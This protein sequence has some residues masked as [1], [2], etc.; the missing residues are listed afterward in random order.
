MHM[1]SLL[2]SRYALYL[3]I[4]PRLSFWIYIERLPVFHA[5]NTSFPSYFSTYAL[6]DHSIHPSIHH[7]YHFLSPPSSP[8]QFQNTFNQT[9]SPALGQNRAKS[10]HSSH[11]PPSQIN[12]LPLSYSISTPST[13]ENRRSPSLERRKERNH[14]N[15]HH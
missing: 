14:L 6:T 13:I 10:K 12:R 3:F 1:G 5:Y 15:Q 9:T 7:I 11:Q 2:V 4:F 8:A